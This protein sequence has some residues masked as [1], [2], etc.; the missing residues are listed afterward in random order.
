MQLQ[1]T[2]AQRPGRLPLQAV[3][4]ALIIRMCASGVPGNQQAAKS[5]HGRHFSMLRSDVGIMTAG[6][7]QSSQDNPDMLPDHDADLDKKEGS[8]GWARMCPPGR[9]CFGRECL[10]DSATG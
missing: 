4:S 10:G 1:C 7:S 5:C 8:R 6:Q 9:I 3:Q 2:V